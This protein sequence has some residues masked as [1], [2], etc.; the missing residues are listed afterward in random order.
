M[1]N[2]ELILETIYFLIVHYQ[3]KNDENYKKIKDL[4]TVSC[5]MNNTIPFG[6]VK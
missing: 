3:T 4:K 6:N 2:P 1:A 5:E